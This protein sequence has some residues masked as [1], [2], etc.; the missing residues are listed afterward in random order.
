MNSSDDEPS[1]DEEHTNVNDIQDQDT[2]P[3][4]APVSIQNTDI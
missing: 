1:V 2:I 4:T 3:D